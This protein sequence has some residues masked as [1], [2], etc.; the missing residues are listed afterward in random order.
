MDSG[1]P[2]RDAI[3]LASDRD[4]SRAELPK[5][6]VARV[7]VVACAL[8][9]ALDAGTVACATQSGCAPSCFDTATSS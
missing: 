8:A 9:A 6:D 1:M 4:E 5:R 2:R 7:E 3:S